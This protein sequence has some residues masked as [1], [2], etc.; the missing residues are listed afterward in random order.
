VW[1]DGKP[2]LSAEWEKTY[3]LPGSL[4]TMRIIPQ[5]GGSGGKDVL[6]IVAMVG[7][8]ALAIGVSA[9]LP[10]FLPAF[11]APLGTT[12]GT[13]GGIGVGIGG[14]LR[15]NALISSPPQLEARR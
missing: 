13:L 10:L 12:I 5:G 2:I 8:L 1:I 7:V 4:V 14:G 9:F 3:P 15:I 11:L 6:R